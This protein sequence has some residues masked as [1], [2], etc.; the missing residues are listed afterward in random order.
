[1]ETEFGRLFWDEFTDAVYETGGVRPACR[2]LASRTSLPAPPRRPISWN[3]IHEWH[4][5]ACQA[6]PKLVQR[7]AEARER[8]RLDARGC[9]RAL[10]RERRGLLAEIAR[11]RNG[12]DGVWCRTCGAPMPGDRPVGKA[13]SCSSPCHKLWL[14]ARWH[15]DED[16]WLAHRKAT[17][18][19]DLERTDDPIRVSSARRVLA[20]EAVSHGRW[21]TSERVLGHLHE[22]AALRVAVKAKWGDL[23]A[24]L[25]PIPALERGLV[26]GRQR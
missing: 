19:Y 10:E 21:I 17:A 14:V 24:D 16:E 2:L 4:K 9:K 15:I 23:A 7:T 8:G 22:V 26:R 3:T 25:P 12:V 1:M 11:I 18:R 20:G 6:D 5:I 13:T